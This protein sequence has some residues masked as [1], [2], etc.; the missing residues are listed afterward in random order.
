MESKNRADVRMIHPTRLI[1]DLVPRQRNWKGGAKAAGRRAAAELV[2][3]RG[4]EDLG[5]WGGREGTSAQS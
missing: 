5:I 3:E 2:A 4:G 1:F